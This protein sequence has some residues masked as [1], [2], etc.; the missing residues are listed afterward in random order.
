M[1]SGIASRAYDYSAGLKVR[2]LTFTIQSLG[3]RMRSARRK[4]QALG[5]KLEGLGFKVY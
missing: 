5:I 1:A 3:L 2:K 4:N